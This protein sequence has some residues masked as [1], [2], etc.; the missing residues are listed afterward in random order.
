M[1]LELKPEFETP[2]LDDISVERRPFKINE[3]QVDEELERIR[4]SHGKLI[5]V[6]NRESKPE[7]FLVIAVSYTHLDVYKRQPPE[8]D[9]QRRACRVS[10]A[11]W[12]RL[13]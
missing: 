2:A 4:E 12:H 6:E 1:T 3:E 7:D 11:V 5:E 9:I 8:T 10:E 13:R